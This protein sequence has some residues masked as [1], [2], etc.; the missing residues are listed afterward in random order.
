MLFHHSQTYINTISQKI[1]SPSPIF[2][3]SLYFISTLSYPYKLISYYSNTQGIKILSQIKNNFTKVHSSFT[4]NLL[5]DDEI[6]FSI[7]P[8]DV[9]QLTQ[10]TD[11]IASIYLKKTKYYKKQQ[12]LFNYEIVPIDAVEVYSLYVNEKFRKKGFSRIILYLSLM[13]FKWHYKLCNEFIVGLHLNPDDLCM[14]LAFSLYYSINFR[15]GRFVK[16]GPGDLAGCFGDLSECVELVNGYG[17]E[18][19]DNDGS[20]FGMYCRYC[21]MLPFKKIDKKLLKVGEKLRNILLSRRV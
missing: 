6:M 10:G 14:H 9:F 19:L 1:L 16:N 20:Y 7:E 2:I 5:T 15:Y 8:Y 4:P 12:T 13:K 11:L 18:R 17:D 3:I 21:D